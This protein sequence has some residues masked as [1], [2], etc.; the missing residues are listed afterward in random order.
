MT[1]A[2]LAKCVSV[3]PPDSR[4]AVV[5]YGRSSNIVKTNNGKDP[6]PSL[7]IFLISLTG[8]Q[9]CSDSSSTVPPTPSSDID[10]SGTPYISLTMKWIV[11]VPFSVCMTP[12]RTAFSTGRARG[13]S[14]HW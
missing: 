9:T 5:N 7:W 13:A 4:A 3:T 8:R 1:R 6:I 2:V 10:S 12:R 14:T 11:P